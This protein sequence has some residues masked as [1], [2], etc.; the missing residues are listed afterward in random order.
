MPVASM[1]VELPPLGQFDHTLVRVWTAIPQDDVGEAVALPALADRTVEIGGDL[2]GATVRLEGSVSGTAWHTLTD[3]QGLP[4]S[5]TVHGLR[6]VTEAT[7]YIRPAVIGGGA[8][9][10]V[11]VHLLCKGQP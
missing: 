9:T 3:P 4:I 10:A 7:V 5:L 2:D 1:P 11:T 6:A 8:G